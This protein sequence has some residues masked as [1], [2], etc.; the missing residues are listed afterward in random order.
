MLQAT[1]KFALH[2]LVLWFATGCAGVYQSA[3]RPAALPGPESVS[4]DIYTIRA[5]LG[6]AEING[7]MWDEIDEQ[8]LP[9]EL[10]RHLSE[11]GFRAGIVDSHLPMKLEELLQLRDQAPEKV[12]IGGTVT[13]FENEPQVRQRHLQVMAGKP[14]N[15]ICMGEQ[16]R[17]P[18]LSV[19][20]RGADGQVNGR[21]YNKVMGLLAIKALP[22]GDSR[23][24]LEVVP[25]LE[26]GD[27]ARR[28][29]PSEGALRVEFSPPHER[30]EL[31]RMQPILSPGQLLLVTCRP[32]RPGS[33]GYQF[34]TDSKGSKPEQ[35]LLLVRL[36]QARYDNL[37]DNQ[38]PQTS[39]LPVDRN[40]PAKSAGEKK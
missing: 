1:A 23:A 10:R 15:I 40:M 7:S 36:V 14:A 26:H 37:F 21:T 12:E 5:P 11:N 6:D 28:F 22:Q 2:S 39:S 32:D 18:E 19:L 4:F 24:R 33:L 25:E 16:A 30:F 34:F 20:T 38:V 35:K 3:P 27:A 13:D 8:Q 31:M 17:L 29:E 9:A